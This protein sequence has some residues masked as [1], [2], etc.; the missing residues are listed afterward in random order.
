MFNILSDTDLCT[1]ATG[2]KLFGF[3]G[4]ILNIIQITIPII[5]ILIGTSELVK[6]IIDSNSDNKKILSKLIT[7][8]IFA[9]LIFFV[10][11]IIKFSVGIVTKETANAC[12]DCLSDPKYCNEKAEELSPLKCKDNESFKKDIN[13]T[14]ESCKNRSDC[15]KLNGEW[16]CCIG[17]I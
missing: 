12:I 2:Y 9:I 10:P 14:D 8:C 3:L 13:C 1:S 5:L 17:D 16:K 6:A 11:M 7:K 15:K 4:H